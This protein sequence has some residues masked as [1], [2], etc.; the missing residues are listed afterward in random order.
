MSAVAAAAR[1]VLTPRRWVA[2]TCVVAG[3]GAALALAL[4]ALVVAPPG[5]DRT[6]AGVALLLAGAIAGERWPLPMPDGNSMTISSVATISAAVMYGPALGA[7]IAAAAILVEL[8]L[9]RIY[10]MKVAFNVGMYAL[11]GG[12]AGLVGHGR[13]GGVMGSVLLA[14]GAA[15]VVNVGSMTL[16]QDAPLRESARSAWTMLRH[17]LLLPI[18]LSTSIA[19]L[20]IVAWQSHPA[21]AL[22]A[23]VPAVA[24][25]LHMRAAQRERQATAL[26]LTDPL[27]GLGNRRALASRLERELDRADETGTPLSV[28]ML[29]LD[30]FK[31]INDTRGHDA[32]DDAL[33]LVADVLRRDGEAYRHGGDE[34]VLVL[35]GR[36]R[37]D[38]VSVGDTIRERMP[39]AVSVGIATYPD[40]GMSRDDVIRAADAALYAQKADQRMICVQREDASSSP[41]AS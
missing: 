27:T 22:V 11:E 41:P 14:T 7:L 2:W 6:I 15:V 9:R 17:H 38:A 12:A 19:P 31:E 3:G 20:F 21:V 10:S 1:P 40:G 37:T 30:G 16:I 26:S 23:A 35:P 5:G 29:D 36:S 28:C 13:G 33:V 4:Q 24:I 18:A 32:G 34:F 39:L 8:L 25:G